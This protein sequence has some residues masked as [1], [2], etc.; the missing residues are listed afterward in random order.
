MS[1]VKRAAFILAGFVFL[2]IGAIG[3]F[4]PILPTTP[5]ILLSAACFYKSSERMHHWVTNNKLFGDY[6]RNYREGKGITLRAKMLTITLILISTAYSAIYML[7]NIIHQ[8][9]LVTIIAIVIIHIL[10]LPTYRQQSH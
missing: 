1:G 3:V 9:I 4:I 2:A 8:I 7:N 10:K 5:F 6:I